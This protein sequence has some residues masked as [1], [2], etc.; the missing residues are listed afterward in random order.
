MLLVLSFT[1]EQLFDFWVESCES[2]LLFGVI[3]VNRKIGSRR[4]NV[5]FGVKDVNSMN[6]SVEAR[7]RESHVTLILSN[8]VLAAKIEESQSTQTY[9]KI[10]R[11]TFED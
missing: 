7:E 5:E 1:E 9:C 6:N 8:G 2:L 11:L 4:H 3:E 10:Y